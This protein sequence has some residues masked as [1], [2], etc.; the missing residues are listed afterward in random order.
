METP[1]WRGSYTGGIWQ[2]VY[3]E[4]TGKIMIDDLFIKSDIYLKKSDLDFKIINRNNNEQKTLL[5]NKVFNQ[6]GDEIASQET[7]LLLS[8]GINKINEEIMFDS[9]QL[10]SPDSH[11][12]YKL[13]SY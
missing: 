5:I 13:K 7:E 3:L 9:I 8:Q 10:W 4:A 6:K 2:N 12:L 1:Q 11:N